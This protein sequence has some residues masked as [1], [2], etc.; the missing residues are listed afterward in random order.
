[1]DKRVPIFVG[2]AVMA[3]ALTPLMDF[4]ADDFRWVSITVAVTYLVLAVL[5]FLDWL[6]RRAR[7]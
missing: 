2:F 5:V 4:G 6:G 3:A 7:R 1:M